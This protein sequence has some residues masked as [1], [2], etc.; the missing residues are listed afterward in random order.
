MRFLSSIFFHKS[1][2]PGSLMLE[3]KKNRFFAHLREV[4]HENS[5]HFRVTI[6]GKSKTDS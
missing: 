4:I 5:S 3:I 6:L 1:V 2:V